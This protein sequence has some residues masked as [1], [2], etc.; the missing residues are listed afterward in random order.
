LLALALTGSRPPYPWGGIL[1]LIETLKSIKKTLAKPVKASLKKTKPGSI[2]AIRADVIVKLVH[3]IEVIHS[4]A[5]KAP[6]QTDKG[7]AGGTKERYYR[8]LGY[9]AQVLDDILK[10]K[11]VSDVTEII[12]Q[13]KRELKDELG[14][15]EK[16]AGTTPS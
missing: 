12:N 16:G 10:N 14:G 7:L 3:A 13:A 8:V 1:Q 6:E 2:P 4:L 5:E 9:L 15:E 11:A